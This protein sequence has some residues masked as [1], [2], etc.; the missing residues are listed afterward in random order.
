MNNNLNEKHVES[1]WIT[2]LTY[3]RPNKVLTMKVTGGKT[4]TIHNISRSTFEKWFNS[5]SK[6]QFF[7]TYIKGKYTINEV[8]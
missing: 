1:T 5:D 8:I 4:Y 3:N 6:G 7:H 2:N